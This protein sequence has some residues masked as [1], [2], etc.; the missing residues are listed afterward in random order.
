M[1][2]IEH[3][4]L[5]THRLETLKDFYQ[6]H[7]GASAGPKY[8]NPRTG[9]EEQLPATVPPASRPKQVAVVGA[10]PAG[11]TC[12][13]VAAARGHRVTLFERRDRAGGMLI[14]GSV[15]RT[16]SGSGERMHGRAPR[17]SKVTAPGAGR[18]QEDDA[19]DVE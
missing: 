8:T 5:W 3:L 1:V 13:T 19:A 14:P 11:I 16:I 15:P 6:T 17:S 4:A 10:G 12:A 9:F 18:S 2:H 7:F